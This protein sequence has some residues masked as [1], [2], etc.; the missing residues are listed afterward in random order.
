MYTYKTINGLTTATY[1]YTYECS[2]RKQEEAQR[3]KLHVHHRDRGIN[4]AP[5]SVAGLLTCVCRGLPRLVVVR[6]LRDDPLVAHLPR[7]R[8]RRARPSLVRHAT[9]LQRKGAEPE[10]AAS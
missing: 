6:L 2:G 4:R 1:M 9:A 7:A 5:R 10:F 3:F 8:D